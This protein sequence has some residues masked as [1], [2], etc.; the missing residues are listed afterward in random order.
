MGSP[1]FTYLV[2]GDDRLAEA[3]AAYFTFAEENGWSGAASSIG[4]PLWDFVSGQTMRKLQ[5]SLLRRI[6]Q[7]GQMVELPF[8]CDG[9]DVRREME[10][11]IQ[12]QASGEGLLFSAR[13]L[14]EAMRLRQGLLDSSQPRGNGLIEMCG[15]CDRFLVDGEWVEVEVAMERLGP[16]SADELPGVTHGVCAQC[17]RRLSAA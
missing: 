5:S 17:S 9:P 10:I 4:R 13:V 2:D 14:S 3:S 15:W 6:R 1:S 12:P 7:T 11:G 8:R 16:M